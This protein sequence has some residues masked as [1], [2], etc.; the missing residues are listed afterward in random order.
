MIVTKPATTQAH[1]TRSRGEGGAGSIDMVMDMM[2]KPQV[3]K[4]LA[5]LGLNEQSV[6]EVISHTCA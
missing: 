5:S 6:K 2:I 4:M 3:E 1:A